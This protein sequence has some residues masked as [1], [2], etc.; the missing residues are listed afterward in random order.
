MRPWWRRVSPSTRLEALRLIEQMP[1]IR[2][3]RVDEGQP[4]RTERI[5]STASRLRVRVSLEHCSEGAT[6]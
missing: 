4:R 5:G 6:E 3:T 2:G 1:V